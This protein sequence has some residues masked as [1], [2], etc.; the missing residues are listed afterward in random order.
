MRCL[1]SARAACYITILVSSFTMCSWTNTRNSP[2]FTRNLAQEGRYD[3]HT[4]SEQK[5]CLSWGLV[6]RSFWFSVWTSAP[7]HALPLLN[8]VGSSLNA[9][10]FFRSSQVDRPLTSQLQHPNP[11]PQIP[12]LRPQHRQQRQIPPHLLSGPPLLRLSYHADPQSSKR[13]TNPLNIGRLGNHGRAHIHQSVHRHS[14][15]PRLLFSVQSYYSLLCQFL[16][17]L[18]SI[19]TTILFIFPS[20]LPF[21]Q[22]RVRRGG[23]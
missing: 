22:A 19:S 5:N 20:S 2:G 4:I 8:S 12:P 1:S 13:A 7:C 10:F 21:A 18:A 11:S 16:F 9:E 15:P 14:P 23:R 3:C 17:L 6:S